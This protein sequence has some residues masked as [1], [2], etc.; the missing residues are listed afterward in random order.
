MKVE[1]TSFLLYCLCLVSPLII[2]AGQQLSAPNG[3]DFGLTCRIPNVTLP[4][5]QVAWF[6]DDQ[7]NPT[8]DTVVCTSTRLIGVPS[9]VPSPFPGMLDT[10]LQIRIS[11]FSSR[12]AGIY[13]CRAI[14]AEV[15]DQDPTF[16]SASIVRINLVGKYKL[17]TQLFEVS[18]GCVFACCQDF[19]SQKML[20]GILL[21]IAIVMPA[22]LSCPQRAVNPFGQKKSKNQMKTTIQQLWGRW[23]NPALPSCLVP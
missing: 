9:Y 16:V 2:P 4:T 19:D 11:S 17:Q 22:F 1:I 10:I 6:F 12:G 13:S 3:S 14:V 23:G 20:L 7:C 21:D 15:V 8:D 5:S 18:N